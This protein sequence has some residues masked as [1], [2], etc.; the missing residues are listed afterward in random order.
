[1]LGDGL[2]AIEVAEA[3]EETAESYEVEKILAKN[4]YDTVT[5]ACE[6][7]CRFKGYTAEHD[8]RIDTEKLCCDQLVA[9]FEAEQKCKQAED[10]IAG[11][12][13]EDADNAAY[14]PELRLWL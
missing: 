8:R 11:C 7:K 14:I 3:T 10:V 2:L 12:C 4:V 1:M 5:G 13:A 9:E 6:Y